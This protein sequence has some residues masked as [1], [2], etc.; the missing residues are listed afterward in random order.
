MKLIAQGAEA[1]LYQDKSN[2]IKDR[3]KKS[4]RIQEID[5]RLRKRRTKK[6]AKLLD[7]LNSLGFTPKLI[8]AD[9]NKII[10]EFIEGKT[11]RDCL[12]EKNYKQLMK[13]LGQKIAILHENNII[14]GDLTTSNF[15]FNKQIYF[16]D[17]GL[18]FESHKVE[19]KAVDLHLLRQALESKHYKIW[20]ECFEEVLKSYK[21][22]EVIERLKLV[23]TRGRYKHK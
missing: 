19:D 2:L 13:E 21:N 1:K 11:L 20:K 7:K 16:I 4:Y 5:K 18:S 6:E 8:E 10:M 23:E 22:K 15:I 12:T 14:H 17:F 9:E 3:I